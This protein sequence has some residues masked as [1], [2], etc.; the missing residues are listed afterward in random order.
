VAGWKL[1]F[2]AD[3]TKLKRVSIR[4]RALTKRQGR[5][6]EMDKRVWYVVAVVIV[7][8]L[9]GYAAGWFGGSPEPAPEA[10]Q[11]EQTQ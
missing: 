2:P 11:E 8:L 7:I 10:Q 4:F 3:P 1:A 5:K 9:I 6:V